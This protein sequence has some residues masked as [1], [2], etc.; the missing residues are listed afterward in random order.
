MIIMCPSV[1]MKSAAYLPGDDEQKINDYSVGKTLIDNGRVMIYDCL[2]S[3]VY[4]E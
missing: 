4:N 3:C 2:I 1:N